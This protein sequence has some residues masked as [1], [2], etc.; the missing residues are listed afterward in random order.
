MQPGDTAVGPPEQVGRGDP[1]R[2]WAAIKAGSPGAWLQRAGDQGAEPPRRGPAEASSCL[3][4][5]VTP[6]ISPTRT[7]GAS[8]DSPHARN[9]A[10]MSPRVPSLHLLP[11]TR[12][13]S[14]GR[15]IAPPHP[16]L[17]RLP[18]AGDAPLPASREPSAAPTP[19]AS[20]TSSLGRRGPS[21]LAPP[22]DLLLLGLLRPPGSHLP[23]APRAPRRGAPPLRLLFHR[24]GHCLAGGPRSAPRLCSA[25]SCRAWAPT[26]TDSSHGSFCDNS[27]IHS[28]AA[29]TRTGYVMLQQQS[30]RNTGSK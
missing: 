1:Q 9:S 10:S 29:A 5:G 14:A 17:S 12:M 22:R 2:L 13:L 8:G 3:T 20:L 15:L 21:H 23:K 16:S 28:P 30:L 26:H 4:R 27:P 25:C 19:R 24:S 6:S 7:T 11:H 18:P